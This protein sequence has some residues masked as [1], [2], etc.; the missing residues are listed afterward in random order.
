M[1]GAAGFFFLLNFLPPIARA[2]SGHNLSG[3][4]WSEN[5]GWIS[6]NS[7]N[8]DANNNGKSDGGAGCPPKNTPVADY[9]VAIATNGSLSGYAWSENIGWISFNSADTSGCPAM[10]C[11]PTLNRSQH[12][13]DGW[14]KAI[15]A[16]G[17]GWDG[18]IRLSGTNYGVT[19]FGCDYDGWAWGSDVVGWIHFRGANYGLIGSNNGCGIGQNDPPTAI[20]PLT[21]GGGASPQSSGCPAPAFGEN[22]SGVCTL[23]RRATLSWSYSDP[24]DD[25][26]KFYQVQVDDNADFSSPLVDTKK[27]QSPTNTYILPTDPV[28]SYNTRYY[29]RVEV[30]DNGGGNSDWVAGPSFTTQPHQ[31]PSV[32]YSWT[33]FRPNKLQRV[34][35]TDASGAYDQNNNPAAP[36]SWRWTFQDGNPVSSSVKNPVARF[37]TTGLK[38]TT[39]IVSDADNLSCGK[40]DLAVPVEWP[41]PAKFREV[42]PQ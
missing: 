16:D 18:W 27:T 4:A 19:A 38:Q 6:F 8:C 39:L 14:A 11:G 37:N 26:Q 36:T 22:P 32:N 42:V 34:Q 25:P 13:L 30:W 23:P 40:N 15:A 21:C 3:F 9:G 17:N 35:F 5:I 28:L 33:P 24:N 10:P 41:T 31:A 2:G 20:N 7:I 29:W 1:I 12:K